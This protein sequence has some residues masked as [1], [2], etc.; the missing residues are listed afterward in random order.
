[1]ISIAS[2]TKQF[3]ALLVL[4]QVAEGRLKLDGKIIDYLLDYPKA[5]GDR[6][7][8]HNLLNHTSG[9]PN[10]TEYG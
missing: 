5:T 7:T 10:Y 9:I 4:Q 3:V 2:V 1:M 8:I 6:I